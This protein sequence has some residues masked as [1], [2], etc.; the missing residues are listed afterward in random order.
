MAASGWVLE[1]DRR[2]E[3]SEDY[4]RWLEHQPLSENTRRAYRVRAGQYLKRLV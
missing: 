2:E 4:G 3:I 1:E